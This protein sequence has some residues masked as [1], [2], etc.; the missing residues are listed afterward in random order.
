VVN[1]WRGQPVLKRRKFFQGRSIRGSGVK[2]VAWLDP[3]GNEMDDAAW[4]SGFVRCLG[5]RLDGRR[6]DEVD[7][8][9][10]RISGDTLL[11]L[12]NAHH[13]AIAFTLPNE[14]SGASWQRILDTAA[15]EVRDGVFEG[16]RPYELHGRAAAVFR[17]AESAG[18]P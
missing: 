2:D 4:S 9:G 11:L 8:R 17:L 6:L 14:E 12:F 15:P 16:G 7:E 1:L 5:V 10:R 18:L 13:D 3:Q